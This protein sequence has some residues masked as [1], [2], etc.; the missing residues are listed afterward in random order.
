M[1][2]HYVQNDKDLAA[3]AFYCGGC[4]GSQQGVGQGV[5]L[6]RPKGRRRIYLLKP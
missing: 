4:P 6:R 1:I 3:L 2:L 5:I